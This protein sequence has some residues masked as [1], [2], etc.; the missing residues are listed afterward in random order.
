M[1]AGGGA[2]KSYLSMFHGIPLN[3][4]PFSLRERPPK[5]RGASY[6]A[7]HIVPYDFTVDRRPARDS[8]SIVKRM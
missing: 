2:S 6:E 4:I 3:H 5:T 1:Q 8:S 7:R